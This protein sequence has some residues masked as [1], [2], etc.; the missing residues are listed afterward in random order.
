MLQSR[1]GI[2]SKSI[3]LNFNSFQAYCGNAEAFEKAF[4]SDGCYKTG[5]IG[6]F[7]D[8]GLLHVY[9]RIGDMIEV[10]GEQVSESNFKIEYKKSL[11]NV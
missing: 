2:N 3:R 6:Y 9:G 5:D 1:H 8:R 11:G 10:E 7:D 4:E